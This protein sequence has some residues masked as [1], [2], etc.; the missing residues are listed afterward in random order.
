MSAVVLSFRRDDNLIFAEQISKFL[1]ARLGPTAITFGVDSLVEPG[2]T[3]REAI[4]AGIKAC[5]VLLVLIGGKWLSV[6]WTNSTNNSDMIAIKT[7]IE[8]GKRIIPVLMSENEMPSPAGLNTVM[9]SLLERSPLVVNDDADMV[10]LVQIIQK[11]VTPSGSPSIATTGGGISVAKPSAPIGL[12]PTVTEAPKFGVQAAVDV[13]NISIEQNAVI[14]IVKSSE[15]SLDLY[16]L[17]FVGSEVRTRVPNG[18]HVVMLARDKGLEWFNV[19]YIS[20]TGQPLPGWLKS[21]SISGIQYEGT[22]IEPMDLPVSRYEY[23]E[24]AE[25]KLMLAINQTKLTQKYNSG[26]VPALIVGVVAG[27]AFGAIWELTVKS[28][29]GFGAIAG[30]M[31]GI[32]LAIIPW[33]IVIIRIQR[34]A[35]GATLLQSIAELT[36][37]HRS[38]TGAGINALTD[39]AK[40]GAAAAAVAGAAGVG[41]MAMNRSHVQK[42]AD[43][44]A[45]KR[46]DIK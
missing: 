14:G 21:T 43:K 32:W 45:Y 10:K 26:C 37:I 44:G 6:D 18:S 15:S 36:A 5:D 7:A 3:A 35:E 12:N 9:T 4:E 1:I 28:S 30:F 2:D 16:K 20:T 8:S 19:V 11:Y 39:L 13:S 42:L 41:L 27:I 46:L 29:S 24:R 33:T 31:L 34:T 23:N 25:V 38:K 22:P 17:P 40:V